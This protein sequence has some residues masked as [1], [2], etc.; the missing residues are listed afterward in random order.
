VKK[1]LSEYFNGKVLCQTINPDEAVAYGAAVQGAILG[2]YRDKELKELVV[3]DVCSLSLGIETAG[4]RMTNVVPRGT[5]KPTQKEQTFSTYTDNQPAVTIQIYEGERAL[6]KDN[7]LLGKFD[8]T[9]IPP[10][11]RGV[12]QI[13]IQFDIDANGILSVSASESSSGKEQRI[14][15]TNDQ[16][17]L[18]AEEIERMIA[19]GEK[20]KAEDE[21]KVKKIDTRQKLEGFLYQSRSSLGDMESKLDVAEAK[22]ARES[23]SHALTWLEENPSAEVDEMEAKQR[24]VEGVV[25][26]LFQKGKSS[27]D[28][29]PDMKNYGG[30]DGGLGG[31]FAKPSSSESGPTVEEL[32]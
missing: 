14:T 3:L 21:A 20:F 22:S 9:G 18:S 29:N 25:Y 5:N 8:L 19:D 26:P 6:T 13:K 2:G 28:A 16:N 23:I 10:M 7:H 1:L 4:G 32:D 11:P 27:T 15:I 30:E 24:E 12:P 17:T 31:A